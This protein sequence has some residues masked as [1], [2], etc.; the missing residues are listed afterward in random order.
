MDL[1]GII[2]LTNKKYNNLN[3]KIDEFSKFYENYTKNI[4]RLLYIMQEYV[5]YND[6]SLSSID[7]TIFVNDPLFIKNSLLNN[8]KSFNIIYYIDSS[9]NVNDKLFQDHIYNRSNTIV[10]D[11]NELWNNTIHLNQQDIYNTYL[12]YNKSY[13]DFIDNPPWTSFPN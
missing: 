11:I 7:K 12:K 13:T 10:E 1:S 5:N 8:D 4:R 2:V 9:Y 6:I 3:T